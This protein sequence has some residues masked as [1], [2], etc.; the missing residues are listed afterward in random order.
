LFGADIKDEEAKT[1]MSSLNSGE[2]KDE[3]P[4]TG[5]SSSKSAQ[6]KDEP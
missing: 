6:N 3:R 5:V 1:G 2:N 4:Q